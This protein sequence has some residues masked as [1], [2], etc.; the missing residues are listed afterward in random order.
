LFKQ[1]GSER[2]M[3][4]FEQFLISVG[5]G[6]LAVSIKYLIEYSIDK[7]LGVW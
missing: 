4:V 6:V 7:W 1:K 2:E 5:A 3:T